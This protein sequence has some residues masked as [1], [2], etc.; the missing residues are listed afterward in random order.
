MICAPVPLVLLN[1][2]E[3]IYPSKTP[4]SQHPPASV[5]SSRP[6]HALPH[7][8]HWGPDEDDADFET[9]IDNKP[10]I[11]S[12]DADPSIVLQAPRPI[13]TE[14]LMAISAKSHGEKENKEEEKQNQQEEVREE[15]TQT[16]FTGEEEQ[17]QQ[18]LVLPQKDDRP[19][20]PD[21]AHEA[22][23]EF[24][25]VAEMDVILPVIAQRIR[26]TS[27]STPCGQQAKYLSR[28]QS[29]IIIIC[30]AVV[31]LFTVIVFE[32]YG[33]LSRRYVP[34][35]PFPSAYFLGP[36]PPSFVCSLTRSTE[37]GKELSD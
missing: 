24:I 19:T 3:P 25:S 6:P 21:P 2:L 29:D 20:R 18:L 33:S 4:G 16:L 17:K 30:L 36:L 37:N 9:V 35:Y 32:T 34:G 11:P 13:V 5:A 22:E 23:D 28:E 12:A 14:Y 10:M 1:A 7:I 8:I 27:G 15:I 31:F 26:L